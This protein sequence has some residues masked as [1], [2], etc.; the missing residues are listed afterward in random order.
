[1][2]P[3]GSRCVQGHRTQAAGGQLTTERCI[4]SLAPVVG[5]IAIVD[6]LNILSGSTCTAS[7]RPRRK[8]LVI[9]A[10]R[11]AYRDRAQYLGDPIS[12][13]AAEAAHQPGIRVRAARQHSHRQ[14]MPSDMLPGIGPPRPVAC[15]P[16]IFPCWTR[17]EIGSRER[18]RST[19]FGTGYMPPKTGVLLKR[20]DG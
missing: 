17:P 20:H 3:G 7:I 19:V 1:M 11:R 6:A 5:R 18:S 12:F 14:G 8:H 10:M 2:D 9:E 16:L 4:V 13:D 15:R